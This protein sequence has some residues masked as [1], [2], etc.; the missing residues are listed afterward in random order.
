[1]RGLLALLVTLLAAPLAAKED[2]VLGLSQNR[3]RITADF[4]G[5]EILI[6]GAV[7]RESP[8]IE[9]PLDVIVTLAGPSTPVTIHKKDRRLGIWVNAETVDIDA[10]PSFYAVASSGPTGEI[11]RQT[12]DLRHSITVPRAI[13][14]VGAASMT[15]NPAAYTEALI[16]IRENGGVY[17]SLEEAVELDQQTLFRTSISLPS[18]LTEG[19]YDTRVFLLREGHVVSRFDTVIDVRKVG[20]ERW[21]F[22]LSREQP[23]AYGLLSLSLAIFA[24]WG[25]SALFRAIR[26]A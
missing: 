12:E 10:A 22:V 2:I 18:N 19:A 25:A 23:L 7:K 5:S 17:Q 26:S 4:D 16:R 21:L 13:R 3:V 11:L 1:M 9:P 24:G 20:L 14:S 8:I 6:F 15:Q